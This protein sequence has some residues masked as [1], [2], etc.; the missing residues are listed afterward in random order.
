MKEWFILELHEMIIVP[1]VVVC[2]TNFNL[3]CDL[4]KQLGV[5]KMLLLWI[6]IPFWACSLTFKVG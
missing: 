3:L 4:G 5:P 2:P 1:H 6:F